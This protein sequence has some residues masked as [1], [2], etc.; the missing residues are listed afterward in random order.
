MGGIIYS[1]YM[2]MWTC[3]FCI[4]HHFCPKI[5]PIKI[6]AIP[7]IATTLIEGLSVES[8]AILIRVSLP[9]SRTILA[10]FYQMPPLQHG[11]IR[12]IRSRS[13]NSSLQS[14]CQQKMIVMSITVELSEKTLKRPMCGSWLVILIE[15]CPRYWYFCL[16]QF[17]QPKK[18]HRS[19]EFCPTS[20]LSL[21]HQKDFYV[22]EE[23][24]IVSIPN[25]HSIMSIRGSS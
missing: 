13:Y 14:P 16:K 3:Y 21:R 15:F 23:K 8:V 22:Y 6:A 1:F 19:D 2:K 12:L 24:Y 18:H 20:I 11:R 17:F 7:M 4:I 9:S 25:R 5:E 10:S